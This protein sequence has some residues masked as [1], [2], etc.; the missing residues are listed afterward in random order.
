L[1]KLPAWILPK[2]P[3]RA[4]LEQM[5]PRLREWGVHTVCE[6]AACPNLGECFAAGTATFLLLGEICTRDCNFCAI[7]GGRPFPPDPDE[8]AR[9]ARAAAAMQLD[10]VVV[11]SVTRDDLP[12]GGAGQF[13]ETIAALRQALPQAKIEVLIPDFAGQEEPLKRVGEA[14]PDVLGHNV[15]TVP[16]RYARVRPGADYQRSLTLL[17]RAHRWFPAITTKSGLMVGLGEDEEEVRSVLRDLRA[18]GVEVVTIGQYLQPT[19]AHLAVSEYVTPEQFEHYE[20]QA[21][22]LGFREV[23]AAPLVRSSYRAHQLA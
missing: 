4:V 6:N 23:S 7:D 14:Q 1:P 2:L 17:R 19:R 21:R 15:E 20:Q 22:A 10:Y 16:S 12:D 3:R 13:A 8:P 11:T 9:I 18:A 5:Q